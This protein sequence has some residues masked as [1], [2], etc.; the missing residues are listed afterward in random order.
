MRTGGIVRSAIV[1]FVLFGPF[2]L[3]GCGFLGTGIN[4]VQWPGMEVSHV[5]QTAKSTESAAQPARSQR[6]ASVYPKHG[7][8]SNVAAR[9][10]KDN[11]AAR[12]EKDEDRAAFASVAG[13]II[14][15]SDSSRN[16]VPGSAEWH[17]WKVKQDL[18]DAKRDRE[19]ANTIN[20]ICRGC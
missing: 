1:P 13:P 10:E 8:R 20:T 11:V 2:L 4:T 6:E 9:A 15:V 7:P 12:A 18:E 17:A 19:L 14:P 5:V 16:P 3:A